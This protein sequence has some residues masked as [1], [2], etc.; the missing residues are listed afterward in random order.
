MLSSSV[1]TIS[2]AMEAPGTLQRTRHTLKKHA[3]AQ[4]KQ[5]AARISPMGMRAVASE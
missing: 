3:A 5:I 2:S 1:E 4:M